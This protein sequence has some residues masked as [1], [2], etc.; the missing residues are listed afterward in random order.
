M[1]IDTS[2]H[3]YV[4][5]SLDVNSLSGNPNHFWVVSYERLQEV[6]V[7]IKDLKLIDV[8]KTNENYF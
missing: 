8:E 7:S 1:T 3:F 5:S 2:H 4:R 6:F